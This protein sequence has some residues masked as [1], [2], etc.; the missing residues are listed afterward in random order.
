MHAEQV[1]YRLSYTSSPLLFLNKLD[2]DSNSSPFREVGGSCTPH[3][4][5][6][7]SSALLHTC[8]HHVC[9]S[10]NKRNSNATTALFS[11]VPRGVSS[12]HLH[13][14]ENQRAPFILMCRCTSIPTPE[15]GHVLL[16]D[17]QRDTLPSPFALKG[18]KD[19]LSVFSCLLRIGWKDPEAAPD[20][21]NKNSSSKLEMPMW[22]PPSLPAWPTHTLL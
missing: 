2:M 13:L 11:P 1:L 9:Y 6:I 12:E 8:V 3:F 15:G 14:P 18:K 7:H 20:S 4:P 22:V 5:I 17:A 10:L 21:W 16:R 19:E